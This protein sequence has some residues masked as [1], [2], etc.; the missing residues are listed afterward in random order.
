MA[1]CCHNDHCHSDNDPHRG[2]VA[3]KR[4]LWAVLAINA[5]MFLVEVAGGLIAGSTSLQADALDFLG[6]AGNYAISLAVVGLTLRTRAMAALVKGAT[7]GIFGL[8]VCGTIVWNTVTGIVP[9]PITMG[10]IG[11]V[12]L[13]ANAACFGLLWAYRSGDANMRSVWVC[14]RNDVLANIA[15][16]LAAVGVFGTGT[17]WPDLLVAAIMAAL[18]LQGSVTVV[19]HARRELGS[20]PGMRVRV[21]QP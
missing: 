21:S 4:V 20:M 3:Y 11:L 15:V 13:A 14:S 10:T 18:A 19:R 2:N 6:D 17:A 8:W 5:T 7:M 12:A 1:G 9:E 16:L